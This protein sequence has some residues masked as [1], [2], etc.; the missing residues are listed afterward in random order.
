[1]KMIKNKLKK[2]MVG[3]NGGQKKIASLLCSNQSPMP[4]PKENRFHEGSDVAVK[5]MLLSLLGDSDEEET[6][7]FP[8]SPGP[9]SVPETPESQAGPSCPSREPLQEV[10]SPVSRS[11]CSGLRQAKR[12]ASGISTLL[13][14]K[15][16]QMS[17][18][19]TSAGLQNSTTASSSVKRLLQSPE[20]AQKGKTKRLKAAAVKRPSGSYATRVPHLDDFLDECLSAIGGSAGQAK[21]ELCSK[22]KGSDIKASETGPT[23]F[24]HLQDRNLK[25]HVMMREEVP[26]LASFPMSKVSPNSLKPTQVKAS[27]CRHSS[28]YEGRRDFTI[29]SEHKV[30][31]DLL[32]ISDQ[33]PWK[34]KTTSHSVVKPR[35]CAKGA[36]DLSSGGG[37]DQQCH[38]GNKGGV[39]G[40][41]GCLRHGLGEIAVNGSGD[42][43]GVMED[44][45]FDDHMEP[46]LS[47]EKEKKS[48]KQKGIP[49]HVILSTGLHNR[50]WVLGMQ[51]VAGPRSFPEKHLIVTA[52]K[53]AVPTELVILKDD[54]ESTPVAVGNIVHLEGECISAT[55]TIDRVSGF[56][57][58]M[59][60]LLISGTSIANSIRCMRRAVLGERFKAFDGGSK[61]MLNG[62]IVHEIFQKA[63]MSR[64]FSLGK[65]QH[66]ASQTLRGPQYLG[67][68][69]SLKLTE[70][71][72]QQ[73]IEEYLPSLSGWANSYLSGSTP[74]GTKQL[75]VNLPTEGRLSKQDAACSVMITDFVDIEEN[76][77]SPRFGLKGKI[78]LTA[79]V[80]IHRR[81]RRPPQEKIMPL[82]LKTGKE[83]NSI[84][85][86]SQVILYTLMSLERRVDAEAGLL[87]Y[88]KTGTVHPIVG[89]HMDRR[90]L[91]KLRN[92]LAH[93]LDN[94]VMRDEGGKPHLAPMLDIANCQSCKYCPQM[95]NCS[96]YNRAVERGTLGGRPDQPAFVEQETQ[97]LSE[98]HLQ[99]FSH[100]VL[101]CALEGRTM[102]RK[103]GRRNIWLLS[104]EERERSGGCM[105]NLLRTGLVKPLFDNAYVHCFV[106]R[107]GEKAE[108]CMIVGDRVVV[109]D[110]E[111]KLLAVATGYV[112]EVTAAGVTCT[113]D[114]NLSKYSPDIMFRLDQDEGVGGMDTHLGNLSKLMENTTI[115][116]KLRELIVDFQPPK[117]IESLSSVLPR[118]AKDT[119][120]NILKGLNKPQKQAMKKVLLSKDYTVI[121]GMPGTG[122]TTT[123]CTLVRILHACGFS[124]LVTSYTH[125]AV[126]NILL[127][128]K[129][130]KIGFLRLGR[131]QKVHPD[132]LPFTEENLRRSREIHT[133]HELERLYSSE[134]VVATTCMGM[135]HPIFS[136]RHFDFCIVDEA[137]Q[138]SQPVCLGPLFYA[139]RFVLVGDHQQLPPIVQNPEARSLGMDESLFKRLEHHKDAV[140]QLTVQ[141]RMNSKIMSL[142]NALVYG[143]KL[144]C[145]S[146]HTAR[147][148]LQL[149]MRMA[150]ERDLELYLS[151]VAHR[152]WIRAVVEPENPICFLDTSKVPAPETVEKGGISNHA[153]A[154]LVHC[155]VSLLLKAGCK[156]GDIGVIAPYRQQ[157]KAILGLL[158][159]P[160]FSAVEV[161][162][163]D[164][165]Q[166][167]DK[168]VII[169]SFVRSNVEGSLGEL[170]KDWRRLNVAITRAKYK[171]LMLGSTPTVQRYAPLGML[172]SHLEREQMIYQL[173][174]GAHESLPHILLH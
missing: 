168:G 128:L 116:E 61:Q 126:D 158:R 46:S 129:R 43:I 146:E 44:C 89:N 139:D 152:G 75:T 165:Y 118:E 70:A 91:V 4:H 135:K 51:E 22:A 77:W 87:L 144:E 131:V 23:C 82:E 99:Y 19:P 55:W 64:D 115:S 85:H 34:P 110:Q 147:S 40:K 162:T 125:S 80:R 45:W 52:S 29:I 49:D 161:N 107:G 15:A 133:L 33:T 36:R 72:M 154:A 57:I 150:V 58:L 111:L 16:G 65:L 95:R 54:W 14:G 117:F 100:W 148:V 127:K 160:A 159:A 26:V 53:T 5:S 47:N 81:D 86:R 76:I 134:L 143:G 123:I 35:N 30:D 122:K 136:R 142:S 93:Y 27:C 88:L 140:V 157:L 132:I 166:G 60:D 145:G 163:V 172:L 102:E 62:T 67:E 1:M 98:A 137:S 84:E 7:N 103:G 109:S 9:L 74:A 121:V 79:R 10:S 37:G 174:P 20:E 169:V 83:S 50:Y 113:L 25:S 32:S 66:F 73:G 108:T 156:A 153:E 3:M 120:A 8:P 41:G 90:E 171:L 12:A 92:T 6:E 59:P 38:L 68:M 96:L 11:F 28:D 48:V 56:L 97:H 130:F 124:V 141:Y 149:P 2:N 63:A 167:R 151:Q 71:D 18:A 155:I 106:R 164:K 104:A 42:D 173:P 13:P 94:S 170:L 105:G 39:G 69:Y 112:T 119:V 114:R 17:W 24:Q 138:I 78:D 101:L 21:Q 31:A